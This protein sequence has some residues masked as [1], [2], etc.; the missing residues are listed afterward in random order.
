MSTI[1]WLGLVVGAF[2][3]GILVGRR[4][5]KLVETAVGGVRNAAGQVIKKL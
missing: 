3:A 1:V 2:I 5:K 4:N